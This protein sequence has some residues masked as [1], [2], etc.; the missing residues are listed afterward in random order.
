MPGPII[1]VDKSEIRPGKLPE[2]VAAVHGLAQLVESGEPRLLGYWAFLSPDETRITVVHIH[3]DAASLREHARVAGPA[4]PPL[5][6]LIRLLRI[7]LYG[8]LDEDVVDRMREKARM[9]GTGTVEVHRLAAGFGRI[10]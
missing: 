10:A 7:D 4:F 3:R 8:E 2:L 9:L 5:A 1:Y 6:G